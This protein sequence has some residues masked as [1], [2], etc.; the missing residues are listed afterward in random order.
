MDHDTYQKWL[1]ATFRKPDQNCYFNDMP[2]SVYSAA[3]GVR[4]STLKPRT[5]LEMRHELL[6]PEQYKYHFALGTALHKAVLEPDLFDLKDGLE[7]FF[8]YCPTKT[9]DSKAAVA[10][11]EANEGNGKVMV[12]EDIIEKA[13]RMRDAIY[14]HK[15]ADKLLNVPKDTEL[16]GFAWDEDAQVLR[17]VRLDMVPKDG[18][19]H[20]DVKTCNDITD[21]GFFW[22]CRD[23]GYGISSAYYRDT[24]ALITGKLRPLFY[25][26]AVT[27]PN[28]SSKSPTDEPYMA[29]VFELVEGDG[30]P[31]NG[32]LIIEGQNIYQDKLTKFANAHRTNC[33][34]A[35]ENEGPVYLS[36]RA[37]M[38]F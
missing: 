26:V 24:D 34:E 13:R 21:T 36:G 37:P 14:A 4:S 20:I 1:A 19:Y 5:P 12:T 15:L 7:E 29:R 6:R 17:K 28:E 23:R 33:W 30:N 16:S 3:P 10:A 2:A 27:G 25:L 31:D 22:A 18:N 38:K 9:F 32:S 8:F 11:L 35:Y